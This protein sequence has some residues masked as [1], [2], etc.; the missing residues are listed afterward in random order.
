MI[1]DPSAD[2]KTSARFAE[3]PWNEHSELW[4]QLD[5]QLP[6]DHL[7]REIRDAMIH[8]DLAPLYTTYRGR[9]KAPHRPDLM[10]AIVLFELRRG[11]RQPS[12]WYQD[13]L[14]P[15]RCGGWALA[16][17]PRAAV[18]MSFATGQERTL[19]PSIRS[20]CIRRSRRS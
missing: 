14:R 10:L 4:R 19:T 9:G 3:P 13:T 18:G 1:V 15:I 12:Q 6:R 8:L 20:S 11:K 17:T 16:S 5:A 2:A 7:A